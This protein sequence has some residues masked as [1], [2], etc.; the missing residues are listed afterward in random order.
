M[1][2][3]L[4]WKYETKIETWWAAAKIPTPSGEKEITYEVV[5]NSGSS[6]KSRW[7]L[8]LVTHDSVYHVRSVRLGT[9]ATVQEARDAAATDYQTRTGASPNPTG[10]SFFLVGVGLVIGVL[11]TLLAKSGK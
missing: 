3:H 10:D 9:F 8:M 5:F 11:G 7:V 4:S 6:P 1:A 2:R